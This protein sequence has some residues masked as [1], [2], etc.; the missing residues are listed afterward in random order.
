MGPEIRNAVGR[1]DFVIDP[2]GLNIPPSS[3][4]KVHA[5]VGIGARATWHY[6][7]IEG[8]GEDRLRVRVR[9]RACYRYEQR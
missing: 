8:A 2:E 1:A 5:G 7:A 6:G 4:V 3:P 9:A